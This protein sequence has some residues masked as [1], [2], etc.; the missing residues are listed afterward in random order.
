MRK[1]LD[2]IDKSDVHD[3]ASIDAH[4]MVW[5]EAIWS[6]YPNLFRLALA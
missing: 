2:R 5:V 1:D 4:E 3:H 6:E